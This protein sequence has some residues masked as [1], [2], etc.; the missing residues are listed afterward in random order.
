MIAA[1][2]IDA[3]LHLWD[4]D[5]SEYAWLG[6]QFGELYASWA[7]EQAE[8]EL[9]TAGMTGAVLVQ[10]EESRVDTRFLLDTAARHEWVLG[11]VGWV[12]LEETD[13]ATHDLE[14]LARFPKF[15]G[16]RTLLNEDP[17]DGVLDLPAVRAS[18]AEVAR[19]GLAFDVHDAWPRHLDAATRVARDLPDLTLVLDHLGKPPAGAEE[20]ASWRASLERFA[21]SGNTVAKLSSLRRPGLPFTADTVRPLVHL[22]LDVFG[23]DRLLY[24]GDWPMTVPTGGYAPTWQVM[25]NVLGEL[26][27]AEQSAILSEAA[28]RVYG[29][30]FE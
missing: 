6:P 16:V 23:P 30:R 7:A 9:R 28:C 26:S 2:R 5:V 10:A 22:A 4:L 3:H 29:I 17:R 15:R 13:V 19:L 8:V 1:P 11:V 18:L 20:F 25:E 21:D 24:G 14:I 27:D 12:D